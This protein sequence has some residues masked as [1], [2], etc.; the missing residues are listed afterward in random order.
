MSLFEVPGWSVPNAPVNTASKKRK[1]PQ[2]NDEKVPEAQ[3]NMQKLMAKLGSGQKDAAQEHPPKKKN[4]KARGKTSAGAAPEK[5]RD[6]PSKKAS[7]EPHV[8]PAS[9]AAPP[10]SPKVGQ[11]NK[12]NK[13]RERPSD[14]A[15]SSSCA[16]ATKS[17]PAAGPSSG[18]TDLQTK[19]QS[20]LHGARFRW[21][22][23]TL[24][25]S[26]SE[27]AH[28]MMRETP[29]VF[30]EYHTGFRH[31]VQSWPSNPV[32][33]YVTVLSQKP[34]KTVIVDL[35][36]GDAELARQLQPR[37]YTVLSYDLVSDNVYV[38]EADICSHIPLPGNEEAE[39]GS[40]GA[41]VV[42]VVVCALSLMGT[43]WPKCVREAWRILREG[44]ELKI[45]EVASR[46]SDVARFTSLINSIGFKL[47][48][49]DDTNTHFTL[50][51]FSKIPRKS[52]TENEWNKIM[53]QS[54]LLKPCEYKR[55]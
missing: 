28:Q 42:D 38:I 3:V 53:A 41:Q 14:T 45:A 32:S 47:Q 31:Q 27:H 11:K 37:G 7:K 26:D 2:G 9:K 19:L 1:R 8:S 52:K 49:T 40:G 29:S 18:L 51:E 36:C 15:V 55:R 21:I 5:H 35:G 17:N 4:R 50:F 34:A 30:T 20:S 44:G 13:L 22:N 10:A 6:A 23:E 16:N 39:E 25:K 43:N 24:Y 54:D 46:F 48:S 12:K 33:H